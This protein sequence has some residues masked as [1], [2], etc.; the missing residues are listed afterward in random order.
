MWTIVFIVVTV[1]LILGCLGVWVGSEPNRPFFVNGALVLVVIDLC[2]L[3]YIVLG[4]G[5][6]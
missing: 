6:R 1:I 4:H 3:G 5:A 2:I